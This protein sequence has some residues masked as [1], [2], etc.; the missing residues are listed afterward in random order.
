MI[1]KKLRF[2]NIKSYGNKYQEITFD[3]KGGLILLTGTNGAGKSTI[4]EAIDLVVFNQVRGKESAKI[5]LKHFP[6]RLNN[7][8]E[9]EVE[10]YNYNNDFIKM[11]RMLSPNDFEM[12]V[13][14]EPYT[15]RFKIMTDTEKE[16]L[17]GF[18]Y[19]TFKSFISMSMNDF[20]NFIHLKPEDKRNLLNRL[21]NLDDI[22]DYLSVTK[23][24]ISQNKKEKERISHELVAIDGELK[25]Y[26]KIIKENKV[27]DTSYST[28][29]DIKDDIIKVKEKYNLKQKEIKEVKD[30][31]SDFQVDI[32][33]NR[34]E[35]S[36]AETENIQRRTELN[37]I[38][39]KIKIYESGQCP[40]CDSK[41]KSHDHS[42]MLIDLKE[43]D[44]ILTEKI[45]ENVG[46]IS[47]YR[48]INS[49]ISNQ[50]RVLENGQNTLEDDFIDIK[51]EAKMLK[52]KYDNF[53]E[54]KSK[55]I[56]DV[57][58][59][60]INLQKSKKEKIERL[61]EI[62]KDN[63]SLIKLSEI[64]GDRGARKSIISSLIPPINENLKKLLSHI[65]FPYGVNLNENF[66]AD[67]YD[68]N[69]LTHPEM[70]SNGETRMLNICIAI[71][72]IQMVRKI[73]D[74]N[75]LFMDEVFQSVQK[76]NI[77][78][79]LK[80]L[81][82]FALENKIHLILVHHGLEEVDSK[83]FDRIISV[84]KD[85]FSDLKIR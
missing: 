17:I 36:I 62:N 33:K 61:S 52:D 69:E 5:P 9:V 60:G 6:N 28:K 11:K 14:H 78:L 71:S 8:L 59:K 29:E 55:L 30:K 39:N 47:H 58:Q 45:L 7:N 74:I 48:D 75:I 80:L 56:N 73:K 31:I 82:D 50:C 13:N 65:N 81:K 27:E 72:Y 46:K 35:I 38:K 64:L 12:V 77:N 18:N 53:N 84:E 63:E 1:I 43:K 41:L 42:K 19:Q 66:D 10:F 54:D 16:N 40:Y 21:F 83:I 85:L 20:L 25:D 70:S 79:L 32:Q 34:N 24:F 67:I 44:R 49:S 51:A 2:R 4:Q 3:N 23:E 68:R 26:I 15:E 76:D 22:D 37:E 57:K